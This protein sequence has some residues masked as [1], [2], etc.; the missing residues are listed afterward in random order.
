MKEFIVE[1]KDEGQRLNKYLK[2]ILPAA[3]DSFIYKMLRK[4]NIKLNALKCEGNELLKENDIIDIYFSDD[5]FNTFANPSKNI[6][7]NCYIKAYKSLNGIRIEYEDDDMAVLYKPKGVLSQKAEAKDMSINEYFIGYLLDSGKI[8]NSSLARFSPTVVNRLDRNTEGLIICAKS[9][10]GSRILSSIIKNRD[11]KKYYKAICKGKIDKNLDLE[12]Y[13]IKDSKTN[14]VTVSSSKMENSKYIRTVVYP[15]SY[16]SKHNI[17]TV[18]ID[19]VTGKSHQIRAHMAYIG[20]PL[21]GDPKYGDKS[22]LKNKY[23]NYQELCSYRV[24]FPKECENSKWNNLII[25]I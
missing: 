16:D 11:I 13:L 5:T 12:A 8:D 17:S 21:V 7:T 6:D 1:K 25:E 15:L 22:E 14:K 20:H 2:R 9:L 18:K 3:S 10:Y 19:L 23:D 24:E 4:K